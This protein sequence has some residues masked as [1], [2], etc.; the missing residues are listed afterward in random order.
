MVSLLCF[1]DIGHNCNFRVFQKSMDLGLVHDMTWG[2][3]VL[4]LQNYFYKAV[5]YLLRLK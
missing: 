4:L 5:I 2:C 3:S 1:Q